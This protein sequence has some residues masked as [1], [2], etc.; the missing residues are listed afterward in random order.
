MNDT[1]HMLGKFLKDDEGERDAVHVAVIPVWAGEELSRGE[2][3]HFV[4]GKIDTVMRCDTGEAAIGIIDP[5]LATMTV[6]KGKRVWLFLYPNT[7]T[8]MKHHWSHPV[9]D[10]QAATRD[11]MR[12][13]GVVTDS[14]KWLKTLAAEQGVSYDSLVDAFSQ[15][16]GEICFGQDIDYDKIGSEMF[17]EHMEDVTGKKFDESH[18]ESVTYRCAC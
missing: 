17:W 15:K 18:R 13:L 7:V 5:F 1:Q 14:E 9:V 4:G 8:G 11:A 12:R 2:I 6:P 16:H 10:G 3:V